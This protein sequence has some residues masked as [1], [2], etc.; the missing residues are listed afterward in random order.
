VL[1]GSSNTGRPRSKNRFRKYTL[2]ADPD[3]TATV[4]YAARRCPRTNSTTAAIAV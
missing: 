2:I 1:I 4:Q 3:I